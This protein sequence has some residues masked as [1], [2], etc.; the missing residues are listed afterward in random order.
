MDQI[1][2]I[3][4]KKDWN[5]AQVA[6][7]YRADSLESEGF[8]H[9]SKPE[10]AVDTANRYYSGRQDLLLLWIDP[11]KLEAELRW[12]PS[13]GD[14]FPHLYGPLNLSAVLKTT[15]FSPDS[16]GVFQTLS[17]NISS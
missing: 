15:T 10:Q 17:P 13:N 1:V 14:V 16:A 5:S 2:H 11:G 6:G 7:E 3:C 9:F 12:E 4:S 8:I